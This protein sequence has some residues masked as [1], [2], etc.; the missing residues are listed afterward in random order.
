MF[1]FLGPSSSFSSPPPRTRFVPKEAGG[2]LIPQDFLSSLFATPNSPNLLTQVSFFFQNSVHLSVDFISH[3]FVLVFLIIRKKEV[4]FLHWYHHVTV[5]LFCWHSLSLTFVVPSSPEFPISSLTLLLFIQ[6]IHGDLVCGD[7]LLRPFHHV[8]LLCPCYSRGEGDPSRLILTLLPLS[9]PPP[10][11]RPFLNS[12][13]PL[14]Y[15]KFSKWWEGCQFC[16]LCVG[17][18]GRGKNVTMTQQTP[19]SG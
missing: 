12:P 3:F 17:N 10:L 2:S 11:S 6:T 14:Q 15:S 8:F 16:V 18:G 7:Q 4:I 9:H 19:S 13:W 5:L 1:V